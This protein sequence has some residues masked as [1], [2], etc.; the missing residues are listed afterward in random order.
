MHFTCNGH[1][2][3][4]VDGVW[5]GESVISGVSSSVFIMGLE[6]LLIPTLGGRYSR[7]SKLM[8]L[9]MRKKGVL[10]ELHSDTKS[11]HE[12]EKDSTVSFADAKVTRKVGGL[13]TTDIYRKRTD[14][15]LKL[16]IILS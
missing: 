2:Y 16:K 3:K 15:K 6:N 8:K 9:K 10:N 11:T 7:L 5:H 4:Q 12:F 1:A 13:F 14:T